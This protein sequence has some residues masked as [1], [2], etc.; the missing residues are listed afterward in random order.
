WL[1]AADIGFS[2]VQDVW[3]GLLNAA[4]GVVVGVALTVWSGRAGAWRRLGLWF[5][6][7]LLGP[8]AC[9]VVGS[10]LG[11]GF[12]GF[13]GAGSGAVVGAEVVAPL[14]LTSPGLLAAWVFATG[15]VMVVALGARAGFGRTW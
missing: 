3:F 9:L 8:G 12:S 11:G 15:L 13:G 6:G 1:A 14:T 10:G 2:A 4:A 7:G 5:G